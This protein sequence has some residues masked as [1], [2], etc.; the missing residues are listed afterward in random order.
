M[1]AIQQLAITAAGGPIEGAEIAIG[2]SVLWSFACLDPDTLLPINLTGNTLHMTLAQFDMYGA[3]VE[4][5]IA[6][7]AATIVDAPNGLATVAWLPSDT[8]AAT[9]PPNVAPQPLPAAYYGVDL[10]RTDGSGNRLPQ[11]PLSMVAIGAVATLP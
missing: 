8:A 4:P 5:P 10:W 3:P 11:L 1:S 7:W 2:T 6:T 9:L